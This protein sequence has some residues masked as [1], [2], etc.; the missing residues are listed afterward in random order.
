MP[1][2]EVVKKLIAKEPKITVQEIAK[3]LN[4]SVERATI[5]VLWAYYKG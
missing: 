3:R 1:L 5:Y 2:N 4:I